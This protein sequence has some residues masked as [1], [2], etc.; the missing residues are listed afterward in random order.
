MLVDPAMLIARGPGARRTDATPICRVNGG[1]TKDS[2]GVQGAG[3][4]AAPWRIAAR[5][6]V[7]GATPEATLFDV[8]HGSA[9]YA[10]PHASERTISA[11]RSLEVAESAFVERRYPRIASTGSVRVARHAG[12]REATSD[13][14]AMTAKANPN[15]SGSRGLTL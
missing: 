12:T 4:P 5:H 11:D 7:A 9:Q 14:S 10:T 2:R 8:Q 3:D 13:A 6:F 15:A 1:E